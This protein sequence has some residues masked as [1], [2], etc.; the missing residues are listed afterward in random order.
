MTIES[1]IDERLKVALT[2]LKSKAEHVF[3]TGAGGFLGAAI[4]RFLCS[5]GIKVTGFARS[6]YPE[7]QKLGV[8][9]IQG[10]IA[11]KE[12]LLDAMKG[13]DVVFHV[14]SKAGVWGCKTEYFQSNVDGA[15]NIIEACK[16][17]NIQNL[18][19]KYLFCQQKHKCFR[20]RPHKVHFLNW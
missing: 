3:V 16:A 11:S 20:L 19:Y 9:M 10:D 15:I 8:N 17:L 5:Q 13:C 12:Q 4:C 6:N 7:L 2:A 1:P 18:V 14:A